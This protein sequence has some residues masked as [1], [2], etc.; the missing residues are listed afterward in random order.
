MARVMI[1]V[2]DE[3]TDDLLSACPQCARRDTS[4]TT[5]TGQVLVRSELHG[6]INF[7]ASMGLTILDVVTI[8][9]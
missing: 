7:L 8:P 6:V 4:Q 2:E 5:P 1:R 3:V 9:E